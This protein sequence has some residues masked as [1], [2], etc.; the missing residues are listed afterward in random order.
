MPV[1][2]R[3]EKES[4]L[5]RAREWL[6]KAEPGTT[7][8]VTFQLFGLAWTHA[9]TNS[10]R[11]IARRLLSEQRADG[12]W[13]QLSGLPSDAYSTGEVL[14]ALNE[15]AGI[16]A[17]SPAYQRGLQFLI[18]SQASDGSWHVQS[19]LH[20]PAPVSP[21]YFEAGFPYKHDQFISMMATAWATTALLRGLPPVQP[22]EK[23]TKGESVG[24]ENSKEPD[25]VMTCLTGTA[26]D[27]KKLLDAGMSPDAKCSGGT[28]ALMLAA[29][30]R[31]KVQLL[32]ERGAN[33]NLP[34]STGI[35]PL[36]VASRY[37]GNAD[38]V[39]LLLNRGAVPNA[40]KS[41]E[42]RYNA[43]A[44][45]Y[46]VMA[47]DAETVQ[48]LLEAGARPADKMKILGRFS[49]SPIFYAVFSSDPRLIDE[50]IARGV[51]PNGLDDDRMSPLAW[52]VIGNNIGTVRALLARGA[53]VNTVD[54]FGMTPLLYAASID[55]GDTTVMEQLIA[56]GADPAAKNRDGLTALDLAKQYHHKAH[57]SILARRTPQR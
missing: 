4:R 49:I 6:L 7:E 9:D 39:R 27:L 12:G 30:D 31:E 43:S 10:R 5:A 18:N 56:A 45:F 22:A 2:L 48:V 55:F 46:A 25:W 3:E 16:E 26:G 20:P 33:P 44:L 41:V 37:R 23:M 51:D 15:S 17:N 36:M 1:A 34:G 19:R 38:V 28:T 24:T 57:A 53:Q 35:T 47:G 50:L 54:N 52:A 11:S 29:R 21:K 32:L 13:G 8:D 14:S 40:D 42:V